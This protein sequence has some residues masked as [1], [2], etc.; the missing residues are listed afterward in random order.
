MT[1]RVDDSWKDDDTDE[2]L[3]KLSD[4]AY[5]NIAENS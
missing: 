3:K 2:V 1:A 5:D 4:V